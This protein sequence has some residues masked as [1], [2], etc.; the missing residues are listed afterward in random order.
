MVRWSRIS[1]IL[2]IAAVLTSIAL[3]DAVTAGYVVEPVLEEYPSELCDFEEDTF[4]DQPLQVMLLH[5]MLMVLPACFFPG[6]LL[7]VSSVLL[8][9]GFRRIT[10]R[11]ILD[12]DFRLD[13]YRQI[14]A[15]PGAGAMEL[16]ELT[17]VSRGRLRHHLNTLIREGKVAAVDHRNRTGHFARNQR[18]TDLEQRIL[19]SLREKPVGTILRR[20]LRA[21]DTTRNDLEERLGLSGPTITRQ[22][23]ELEAEGIIAAEKDGR[24]V[25]YRLSEDA[26]EFLDR[27]TRDVLL[28]GHPGTENCSATRGSEILSG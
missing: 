9:F 13:L 27:H 2:L 12:D 16:G 26:W 15:N 10:K 11:T 23:Q 17:G 18:Y 25:R 1:S 4:R 14:V 6:E 5:F 19:I 28:S 22:M 7:Y 8:P 24:F 3:P 20:L 21:P